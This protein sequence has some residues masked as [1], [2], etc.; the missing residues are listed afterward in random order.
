MEEKGSAT[1]GLSP[2][3]F[4]S[5]F[6]SSLSLSRVP[7]VLS[8]AYKREGWAPHLEGFL[9]TQKHITTLR[10]HENRMTCIH[11]QP[12]ETWVL[13]PLSIVCNPYY[14]LKCK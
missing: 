7:Q 4:F 8:L 3:L 12:I 5:F 14:K 1:L 11:P 2:S 9:H 13:M 10:L 6:F